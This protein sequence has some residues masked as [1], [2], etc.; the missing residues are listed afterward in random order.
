MKLQALDPGAMENSKK[1]KRE[2]ASNYH[3]TVHLKEIDIH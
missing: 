2:K 1:C 3:L